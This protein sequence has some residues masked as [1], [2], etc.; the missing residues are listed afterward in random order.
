MTTITPDSQ[1]NALHHALS[2]PVRLDWEAW[3]YVIIF[4]LAVFT[5]FY[6]LGDRV[7]S[8]DESLHT[9]FSWN[10]Y[11]EGE[12]RHTPLMHG[13]ILF[14]A[15]A[16]SYSMFG[17]NDFT[18]RIYTSVL[19][20]LM[21]LS[22]LL[23]RYWLGRWGALIASV[24]LLISPLLMFYNRYIREDT[25]AIMASILMIWAILMYLSGPAQERR[26]PKYLYILA[27]AMIWNLGSKETAFMYIAVFGIFLAVFWFVRL[28]QHFWGI[29]GKPAFN[30]IA[31]G[32]LLGGVLTL[33]M[34]IILD[35]IKFD[36]F[37]GPDD[38]AF[39]Q[40]PADQQSLYILWVL[41]AT[42]IVMAVLLGTLL[43]AYRGRWHEIRWEQVALVFGV[44]MLVCFALVVFEERSHTTPS[45][46]SVASP[47]VPGQE[48]EGV[49]HT[50]ALR[51][52]PMI[53]AWIISIAASAIFIAGRRRRG[54]L[55]ADPQTQ[56]PGR[57][58]WGT[59]DLFPEFDVMII[60]GTLVLPWATALIPYVMR[61]TSADFAALG[62]ALPP[63]LAGIIDQL[64][65]INGSQQI[66]QFMLGFLAWLPL[67]TTA[68]II[69]LSWDWKKWL[70]AAGIFHAIF[71]FFFTTIFTNMAGLAT[72][73]IYSL[74]YWLEQQGVR[75][76]SQPQYYYLLIILPMYE[77]LAVIGSVCAMFAGMVF[78]WRR[79]RDDEAEAERLK[80]VIMQQAETGL[81]SDEAQL[82]DAL[83]EDGKPKPKRKRD[84]RGALMAAMHE[85]WWL[86]HPPFL[87]FWA[88]VAVFNLV[89]FSLAGEKMPWLGTHLTF[90]IIFLTAWYL[91]RIVSR[92]DL[93]KFRLRGWMILGVYALAV[94]TYVQAFGV[95]VAG[96]PPFAG[97]ST[98]QLRDTYNF[99]GSLAAALAATWLIW[100]WTPQVGRQHVRHMAALAIFSLLGVITF[101]AAW[102][103]SFIN[104]DHPTEFLVYAHAAP[105]IKTVLAQIEEL[106]L[107]TT[108]GNKLRFAYDNEVSWPY[109][110]YFRNFPNAVFVGS[111][112]TVQNLR[113]AVVVVVGGGNRSKVE[114]ILE[115][116]YERYS[117]MRLWWPMQEYFNLTPQRLL[118]VLDFNP[119]NTNAADLRKAIFDI[120][121]T[122]DYSAYGRATNRNY[123][124]ENWPV[125]DIMYVYIRKD[126]AAQIWRYGTGAA[127]VTQPETTEVNACVANWQPLS[128]LQILTTPPDRPMNRPLD[129]ALDENGNL[130]VAEEY[131]HRISVFNADG[132]YVRSVGVQ[133]TDTTRL[134]FNRPN[135]VAIDQ[136]GTVYVADTWNFRIAALSEAGE[137]IR[138]SWGQPGTFGF[139]APIEPTDAFWGPRD[140]EVDSRGRIYVADTGNKRVRVYMLTEG[141]PTWLYDIGSGGSGPGQL[142]EPSGLAIS[143]DGRLF[144]ADTWNRRISVFSVDG[145]FLNSFA[146]RAWYEELGN[147]PYLALDEAR[148]L[149]Y[150]TDADGGR[151]L[152]YTM[153]GK[154]VGSFGRGGGEVPTESQ[155]GVVGG[156]A[157]A[158]DG[159]V[160]VADA[161]LNRVLKFPPFPMASVPLQSG[162]GD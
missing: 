70:I 90:P 65:D 80:L 110:W 68:I 37:S 32:T 111:N 34:Y 51:W 20:V 1:P 138:A 64:P 131:G 76:G 46:S 84:Q 5:R 154:C 79:N 122:R 112:P 99:L 134:N 155:I 107:R 119:N 132:N 48:G 150:V 26:K 115:D 114:P 135:G 69:G 29:G 36:L 93:A 28:A 71:V 57:G 61:G 124:L 100:R 96:N 121:W 9:R 62:N 10:L 24:L 38:V 105:A 12:F 104:Y 88:W 23:F 25:P 158:S 77:F 83:S 142:D 66:G 133:G 7:M 21:V 144:V 86:D 42:G 126:V 15:I 125:S 58:L 13:P 33:G 146:V 139:E 129:L 127:T 40:L 49:Q 147:R 75:R 67:M 152:V 149:L 19:G 151:V 4:L 137:A 91:G 153:S 17:D 55:P 160:I 94:V 159:T 39:S 128:A 102:M 141:R 50:N 157:V 22:P 116:R 97:L 162:S 54:D 53:G 118:N 31:I 78:F 87:L 113:D 63:F 6:M 52:Y 45:G 108:D 101:R 143:Q 103:A 109:S 82:G 98:Q 3:A 130:W 156:I 59:L 56:T 136:D 120:W 47:V 43:W 161:G 41:L 92:I 44:M 140:V 74:G 16:L 95:L 89:V 73:M 14:H 30:F 35:I 8:H 27:A 117:H 106:S 72:G 60:I 123:N 11:S 148:D 18:A 145:A 2:R 81:E 85:R